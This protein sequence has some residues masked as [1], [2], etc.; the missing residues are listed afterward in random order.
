MHLGLCCCKSISDSKRIF[1]EQRNGKP[2]KCNQNCSGHR[3]SRYCGLI[4]A[5]AWATTACSIELIIFN[6]L[7]ASILGLGYQQ[8]YESSEKHDAREQPKYTLQADCVFD[9]TKSKCSYNCA[10]FSSSTRYSMCCSSN[11]RWKHFCGNQERRTIRADGQEK[12]REGKDNHQASCRGV[13]TLCANPSPYSIKYAHHDTSPELL[14]YTTDTVRKED[15]DVKS[16]EIACRLYDYITH[17]SVV[18][19]LPGCCSIC[20][21]DS[22]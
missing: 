1:Q 3:C 4:T 11:P 16:G 8:G 18:Q 2:R 10:A 13:C 7:K 17:R 21:T 12:L 5:K 20:I 6:A 9:R 15:A 22:G 19:G 14:A